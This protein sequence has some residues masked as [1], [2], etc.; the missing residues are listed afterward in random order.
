VL[1]ETLPSPPREDV[2]PREPLSRGRAAVEVLVCSGYPTQ[3]LIGILLASIGVLP[4]PDG[5]LSAVFLFANLAIDSVLLLALIWFFL[6]QA[7]DDPRRLF[8]GSRPVRDEVRLGLLTVPFML[9]V[10]VG[11]QLLIQTFAPSLRNVP[12]SPFQDLLTSR[13]VLA[14]FVVLLVIAGGVREELQRAF[15]L[16]RFEHHLGGPGLG[17]VVTSLAFGLG[18][19]L[20]GWDAAIATGVLGAIW[21]GIYLARRSAIVPI[22]SHGCFNIVQVVAGYAVI[23][24]S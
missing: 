4:A 18:H 13:W 12:E 16:H 24:G 6:R 10:V 17:L 5:R 19:T 2:P 9:A 15:L 21:A 1:P 11:I 7:G 23:S 20:Q 22:A 8:L 3:L 14:G